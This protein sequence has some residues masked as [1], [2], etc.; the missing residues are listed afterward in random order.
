MN[1]HSSQS[2]SIPPA[3]VATPAMSPDR[4]RVRLARVVEEALGGKTYG[5]DHGIPYMKE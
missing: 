3:V 1:P 2:A 5:L 4:S